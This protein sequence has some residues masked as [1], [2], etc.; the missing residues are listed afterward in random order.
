MRPFHIYILTLLYVLSLSIQNAEAQL[1]LS[2]GPAFSVTKSE[3]VALIKT[4]P[5]VVV[6]ETE[7]AFILKKYKKKPEELKHYKAQVAG[8]NQALQEAVLETWNFSAKPQF[9]PMN[10][11]LALR[12]KGEAVVLR[13]GEVRMDV[14]RSTGMGKIPSLPAGFYKDALTGNMLFNAPK[15][16]LVE[17]DALSTVEILVNKAKHGAIITYLPL[18]LSSKADITYAIQQIQYVLNY[19][20]QGNSIKKIEE[21]YQKNHAEL[22]DKTLLIDREDLDDKFNENEVRE[23]YPYP[24]EICDREKID[25]VILE[26]DP[27][28]AFVQLVP[29]LGS[30]GTK[31]NHYISG[32]EDGKIYAAFVKNTGLRVMGMSKKRVFITKKHL[33]FYAKPKY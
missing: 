16:E 15:R 23:I 33:E 26:K 10:E 4:R 30:K 20:D 21:Q 5:L 12:E 18:G 14:Y 27:A 1:T 13:L 31:L 17:L 3:N 11:A 24:F 19:V 2:A 8:R 29:V 25:K 9:M 28:Y 6:L 7:S 22:K 32:G